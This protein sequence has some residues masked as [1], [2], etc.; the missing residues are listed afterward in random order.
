[1]K[2]KGKSFSRVRLFV[3]PWTVACQAPPSM[4]FSRQEY[5][6]GLQFP[7]PEDLP[8]TGIEPGFLHCRR[9]LYC[10]SHQGFLVFL[11]GWMESIQKILL[12][13]ITWISTK[14]TR[15]SWCIF[16]NCGNLLVLDLRS[17]HACHLPVLLL[18]FHWTCYMGSYAGPKPRLLPHDHTLSLQAWTT[19]HTMQITW[20]DVVTLK[21]PCWVGVTATHQPFLDDGGCGGVCP[22]SW[23]RRADKQAQ[24]CRSNGCQGWKPG[25]VVG[26]VACLTQGTRMEDRLG[27]QVLAQAWPDLWLAVLRG[28][29]L[30]LCLCSVTWV[31]HPQLPSRACC[32]AEEAT[33]TFVLGRQGGS[34]WRVC[35]PLPF[36]VKTNHI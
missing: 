22:G 34:W 24:L 17:P 25:H 15:V 6:S 27:R 12:K 8:D 2:V 21:A 33:Q 10:L 36:D 30:P 16:S 14:K 31:K 13:L 3:T 19:R 1:M 23:R 35:I 29:F 32:W 20:A 26:R 9:T 18:G 11:N 7:S 4:G 5:W 28:T